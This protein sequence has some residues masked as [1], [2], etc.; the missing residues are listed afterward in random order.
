MHRHGLDRDAISVSV[1]DT[2]R[3]F[4]YY[5]EDRSGSLSYSEFM[6]LLQN[7]VAIDYRTMVVGE[8]PDVVVSGGYDGVQ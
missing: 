4:N 3:L 7:S 1:E 8:N 2:V 5:D 6:R